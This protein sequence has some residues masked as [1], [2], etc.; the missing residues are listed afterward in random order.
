MARLGGLAGLA[1]QSEQA[2]QAKA[3]H[4]ATNNPPAP[5]GHQAVEDELESAVLSI[6]SLELRVDSLGV[7]AVSSLQYRV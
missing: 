6:R 7:I 4:I 5:W 1:R 2:S 3:K